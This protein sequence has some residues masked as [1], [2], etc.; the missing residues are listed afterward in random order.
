MEPNMATRHTCYRNYGAGHGDP[1]RWPLTTAPLKIGPAGGGPCIGRYQL[2][3]R[4]VERVF[5]P[6]NGHIAP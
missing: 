6:R 2:G 1:D 5:P 4:Q 3:E